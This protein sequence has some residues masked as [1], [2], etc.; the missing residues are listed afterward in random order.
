MVNTANAPNGGAQSSSDLVV[1]VVNKGTTAI[2]ANGPEPSVVVD[3]LEYVSPR[4]DVIVV[5]AINRSEIDD[6]DPRPRINVQITSGIDPGETGDGI[7][8]GRITVLDTNTDDYWY[9]DNDMEFKQEADNFV[10]GAY[11]AISG[12][13]YYL[14]EQRAKIPN[15]G[16]VFKEYYVYLDNTDLWSIGDIRVNDGYAPWSRDYWD[17]VTSV[18]QIDLTT[19]TPAIVMDVNVITP[20][21]VTV[22]YGN[23]S[24]FVATKIARIAVWGPTEFPQ[25][26]A[27]S[28]IIDGW[29]PAPVAGDY[30]WN[31][32]S[33]PIFSRTKPA[34]RAL[35]CF[36][37]V[38]RE[39][40]LDLR[41]DALSAPV[42]RNLFYA[43]PI[44]TQPDPSVPT[45][46]HI[47]EED[48]PAIN[49]DFVKQKPTTFPPSA[50]N[51]DGAYAP[52]GHQHVLADITDYVPGGGGTNFTVVAPLVLTPGETE[53]DPSELS[54]DG[55]V[56]N[57]FG[58]LVWTKTILLDGEVF[59]LDTNIVAVNSPV[60]IAT[61]M[62]F[63]FLLATTTLD[64]LGTIL[65]TQDYIYVQGD[66]NHVNVD[67]T[68]GAMVI[69]S[70]TTGAQCVYFAKDGLL[71][72]KSGTANVA[73]VGGFAGFIKTITNN[74]AAP[75]GSG[76]KGLMHMIY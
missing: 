51:H 39:V 14:I 10:I 26:W 45:F 42:A 75:T 37:M 74:T 44:Q 63:R 2:V 24:T 56:V 76:F 35:Y 18:G 60:N 22:P 30:W 27:N 28:T 1:K 7:I 3:T 68:T 47:W 54:I 71:Y 62:S 58:E 66:D 43:G 72:G 6:E 25:S 38:E 64:E 55:L 40:I 29:G 5:G 13:N 41:I 70:S 11:N 4:R 65:P 59:T 32:G 17:K 21:T 8:H 46:R 61:D 36:R 48:L 67:S 33:T 53:E 73:G 12:I 49:W 69:R 20:I 31:N 57:E 9:L 15:Q 34:G 23:P 19:N 50:H 52:L 16:T